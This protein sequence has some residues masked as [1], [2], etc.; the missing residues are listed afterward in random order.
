MMPGSPPFAE[1]KK[2]LFDML[3]EGDI[4]VGVDSNA[5][6]N[7]QTVRVPLVFKPEAFNAVNSYSGV[8]AQS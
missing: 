4:E 6:H 1:A 3:P 2:E 8:S 5:E 7:W